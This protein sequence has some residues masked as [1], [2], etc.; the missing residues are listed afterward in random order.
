MAREADPPFFAN[1]LPTPPQR[2][3][4]LSAFYSPLLSFDSTSDMIVESLSAFQ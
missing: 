3:H 1:W 4:L 2:H